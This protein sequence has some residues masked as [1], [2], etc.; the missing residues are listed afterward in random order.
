[1]QIRVTEASRLALKAKIFL[2]LHHGLSI[3]IMASKILII[4]PS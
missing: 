3:D 1:M 4:V 2:N